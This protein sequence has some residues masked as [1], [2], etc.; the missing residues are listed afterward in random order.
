MQVTGQILSVTA[1]ID[2]N[3]NAQM[4]WGAHG[5]TFYTF[6]MVVQGPNGQVSGE[7]NST[8]QGVYPK[9]AGDQI[10]V[11]PSTQNGYPKLKAISEQN[12]QQGQQNQGQ[13]NYQQP[14][15]QGQQQQQA[16]QQPPQRSIQD[17]IAF[18][19][20]YN[21]AND[22]F[23]AD[24]IEETGIHERA[25]MHYKVL[26][27]RQFPFEMSLSGPQQGYQQES[28]GNQTPPQGYQ[29]PQQQMP[30]QYDPNNAP[31]DDNIPF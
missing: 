17:N 10:T 1:R 13:Q 11:E 3:T 19:Q 14:Q 18:G 12:Q 2:N 4:S 6:D 24:K 5:K 16:P 31:P 21:N 15:Q 30:P 26:T 23:R 28:Q 7:I 27:T 29:A 25:K 9:A 8:S 22:D 20:A